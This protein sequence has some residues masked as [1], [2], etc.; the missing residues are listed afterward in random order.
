MVGATND[1]AVVMAHAYGSRIP[2]PLR[3]GVV[4]VTD[5]PSDAPPSTCAMRVDTSTGINITSKQSHVSHVSPVAYYTSTGPCPV[6]YNPTYYRPTAHP[7]NPLSHI[8]PPPSFAYPTAPMPGILP[9]YNPAQQVAQAQP[10]GYPVAHPAQQAQ[11]GSSA[12]TL[13]SVG[14]TVTT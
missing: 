6:Y 5:H 12:V 10:F 8:R 4:T 2:L 7:V 13:G 3:L 14:P 1:S 9:Y 11:S